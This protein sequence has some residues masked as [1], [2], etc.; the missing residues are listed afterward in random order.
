MTQNVQRIPQSLNE[1][2]SN[3]LSHGIGAGL[4]MAASCLLIRK[5]ALFGDL[6]AQISA[7][8]YCLS[9]TMLFTCSAVYHAV[10]HP[11]AK[12]VF[13]VIDHCSI[14]LLIFGTYTPVALSLI[15]GVWGLVTFFCQLI[16]ASA[17]ILLNCLSLQRYKKLSMV[18][19]ISSGWFAVMILPIL[20]RV[21]T[22]PAWILLVS[23]GILYTVGTVFYGNRK[24]RYM[25]FVWHL[26][27]LAGAVL[28][29]FFV[30]GY[31]L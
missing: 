8:I 12:A 22:V 26:F 30:Y 21:L 31:C 27:V 17:G 19:Y 13:Q 25:H 14:F 2:F 16:C 9:L 7:V 4:S 15:G 6:P 1:E 3:V 29:F 24:Y 10:T 5:A 28:H 20:F 11:K 23:G 18:M